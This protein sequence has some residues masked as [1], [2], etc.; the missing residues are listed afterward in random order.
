MQAN[1]IINKS[2]FRNFGG[3]TISINSSFM[4]AHPVNKGA[5]TGMVYQKDKLLGQFE[6]FSSQEHTAVQA[7]VDLGVFA[8]SFSSDCKC[9]SVPQ[10]F[11]VKEG[12]YVFFFVAGGDDGFYVELIPFNKKDKESTYSTRQLLKG[13][14]VVSL[15]MRPGTY[16]VVG[17][18]K[19][20]C[21]LLVE[22]PKDLENYQQFLSKSNSIILSDKGFSSKELKVA[23]GQGTVITLQK[24]SNINI[25][26]VKPA[27]IKDDGKAGASHRWQKQPPFKSGKK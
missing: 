4:I 25:V 20:K 7:D 11:N 22:I 5:Y 9:K 26:L 12:G 8:K 2:L 10:N 3:S 23:P 21:N 14:I 27:E 15:L 18:N 13:D 1:T 19:E 6:L 17:S 24:D 16:E